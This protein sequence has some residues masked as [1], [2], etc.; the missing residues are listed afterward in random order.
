[1]GKTDLEVL[2]AAKEGQERMS[3]SASTVGKRSR[4][5]EGSA[6]LLGFACAH[7]GLFVP[8]RAHGTSHRNH[9]PDCL[10]SLHVDVR[11]GD[12]AHLCRS[13]MEPVALWVL[14]NGERRVIHRCTGCGT[15]RANRVAGD[16]AEGALEMLAGK[17][18][19]VR[20]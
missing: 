5:A 16:D 2:A 13:P 18:V 6:G 15:L 4:A 19:E 10:W 1:M 12:R 11:P 17:V 14:P 7:C 20:A 3:R 9:C 8:A